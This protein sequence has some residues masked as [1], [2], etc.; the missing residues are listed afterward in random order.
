MVL[1]ISMKDTVYTEGRVNPREL[2][3]T[4]TSP[5]D[6]PRHSKWGR[7]N[8][9]TVS[10]IAESLRAGES[11]VDAIPGKLR[12]TE[13][14]AALHGSLTNPERIQK[15]LD[16]EAEVKALRKNKPKN[17]QRSSL[18]DNVFIELGYFDSNTVDALYKLEGQEVV[19]QPSPGHGYKGILRLRFATESGEGIQFKVGDEGDFHWAHNAVGTIRPTNTH[20]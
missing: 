15:F 18:T 16:S 3:F 12:D 8:P 7:L 2:G 5:A 14:A 6:I 20:N 10:Q 11:V 17:L 4:K 13:T 1:S 19:Y 9:G